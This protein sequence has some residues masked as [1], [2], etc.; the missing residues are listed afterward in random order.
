MRAIIALL[1]SLGSLA[2]YAAEPFRS[3][4]LQ[5]LD[6]GA[7][8]AGVIVHVSWRHGDSVI[9]RTVTATTD[10]NGFVTL[11]LPAR[12]VSVVVPELSFGSRTLIVPAEE[13][14][15]ARWQLSPRGW[16]ETPK[17]AT[18]AAES[19]TLLAVTASGTTITFVID[20]W[21]NA[22]PSGNNCDFCSRTIQPNTPSTYNC[23]RGT[24]GGWNPT[25]WFTSP[26]PTSSI[27]TDVKA[28]VISKNCT[29]QGPIGT[30]P[31]LT[32]TTTL[33]GTQIG[34]SHTPATP[35]CGCAD[36]CDRDQFV[37]ATHAGGFPGFVHGGANVFGINI[38]TGTLCVETVEITLTYTGN[39][40]RLDITNI[41][42][43]I[44]PARSGLVADC[45]Q[46]RSDI[47]LLATDSGSPARNVGIDVASS[48]GAADVITQPRPTDA[49]GAAEARVLT[50]KHGLATFTATA[51]GYASDDYAKAFM[52]ADFENPFV[53][54]GYGL[55]L[56]TD[57]RGRTVTGPCGLTGTFNEDFL[58]SNRGVLMEGSGQSATGD[59]ITIDWANSGRP[60]RRS[61]VCFRVDTCARTA[62]GV[63][64]VAG[65]TIAVDRD[66]IPFD[67]QVNIET[68]GVRTAQDTGGAIRG[69]H[70][71]V[72]VGAG[73]ANISA[74]GRNNR[75]V[76]YIGGG[77]SCN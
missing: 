63:C 73:R 61:N 67:A 60:L 13:T 18:M 34:S 55:P 66:V 51:A 56:E 75:R 44:I 68:V 32:Y 12:A 43:P 5:I 54:T 6:G 62:S 33:N 45:V 65:T 30:D 3:V 11:Q 21:N 53:I 49:R 70:I 50:R 28:V 14:V 46:Y 8:A 22:F 42:D 64:A 76:R 24:M 7:P 25:C 69:E 10:V 1:V 36:G 26:V 59:I 72:F 15:L 17:N 19:P 16:I 39:T 23:N 52:T 37:S 57:F 38:D 20:C 58:Y 27:V 9:G 4:E 31:T 29:A 74:F 2:T 40:K 48:R 41:S 47:S 35:T 77:G 71:D